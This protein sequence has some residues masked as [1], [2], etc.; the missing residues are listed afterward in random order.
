MGQTQRYENRQG[1]SKEQYQTNGLNE[2]EYWRDFLWGKPLKKYGVKTVNT[3]Q[4]DKFVAAEL[5][6]GFY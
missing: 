2:D 5:M 1:Q 3:W 4:V 6:M